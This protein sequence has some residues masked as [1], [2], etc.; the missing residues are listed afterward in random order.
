MVKIILLH[1]PERQFIKSIRNCQQMKQTKA[2]LLLV[3]AKPATN[4]TVVQ[5]ALFEQC[6]AVFF[7]RFFG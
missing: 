5:H 1:L 3:R 7:D 2:A 6:K 4:L